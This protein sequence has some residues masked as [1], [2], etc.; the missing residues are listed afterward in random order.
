MVL[1]EKK[2]YGIAVGKK[3][4]LGLQL[5]EICSVPGHHMSL[6]SSF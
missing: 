4:D 1:Q 2:T 5:D 6:P 3:R